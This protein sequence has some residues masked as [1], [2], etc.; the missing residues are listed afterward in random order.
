MYHIYEPFRSENSLKIVL[1]SSLRSSLNSFIRLFKEH[2][3]TVTNRKISCSH[4]QSLFSFL[5]LFLFL[6]VLFLLLLIKAIFGEFWA[7][8]SFLSNMKWLQLTTY[9]LKCECL[10]VPWLILWHTTA[11]VPDCTRFPLIITGTEQGQQFSRW[12]TL[13]RKMI[14][15]VVL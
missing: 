9:V 4:V 5:F 8:Q 3:A 15:A 6:A 10:G 7:K 2:C 14:S 13:R 11:L 12:R 1:F